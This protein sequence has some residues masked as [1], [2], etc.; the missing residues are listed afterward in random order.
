MNLGQP[1][2]M[3]G[4][5]EKA[6]LDCPAEIKLKNSVASVEFKMAFRL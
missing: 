1:D 6:S 4:R 5:P 3:Y 2:N